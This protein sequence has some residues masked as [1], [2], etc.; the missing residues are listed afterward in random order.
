MSKSPPPMDDPN[1]EEMIEGDLAQLPPEETKEERTL[2]SVISS[3]PWFVIA[4]LLHVL[5]LTVL[6][7]IRLTE[8]KAENQAAP[9]QIT[10]NQPRVM[11]PVADTPP[12]EIIDRNQVPVLDNEQ[13]GPVNPD[14]NYI[15]EA[16]PGRQGEIIPDQLDPTKDPGIYNPDPEALSNL[17]SGATGGTAIGVGTQG[18][19][20]LGVSAFSSRRA[21]GDGKGGGGL[22][23]GGGGGRGGG[24]QTESVM[25]AALLWLANHQSPDGRWDCDGFDAH[26][27]KN[28]CDGRGEATYDVGVTGLALLC[29]LGAGFT[30]QEGPFKKTVKDGLLYLKSVQDEDGVFGGKLCPHYQ[31]NHACAAL[32]M[33]EAY[34]MTGANAFREPAVKGVAWVGVSQ[35]PYRAWRYGKADGDNDSSVTG[36]MTM[37]IKSAAMAGID[38]EQ[39]S[40]SN[41]ANFIDEMTEDNGRTGYQQKGGYPARVTGPAMEKFPAQNSES[42]TAVGILVRIFDGRT[43]GTDPKIMKGAE[44]LLA[45][46]PKWDPPFIDF[47]YWY[48]GTLAMYQ[49]GGSH[50]DRWNEAMKTAIIAHQNTD[51]TKDEFGSWDPVDP[52]SAEGGRVYSTALNCLCMEVYYR[53]PRVFGAKA[54]PKAAAPAKPPK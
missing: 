24:K 25:M 42:L 9:T 48:Y 19:L 20:G 41:A 52:W 5:A 16:T 17:P 47:Y 12:P 11:E 27:K 50:F 51:K 1:D 38:V 28:K 36:W 30:H 46:P 18:H 14:P 2:R 22:G 39:Q 34:G 53:Y 8:E 13:E 32:A 45:Q 37:V 15:P 31:Y 4:V 43:A 23:Q 49:V 7:V 6:T 44:L 29:F 40:L 33:A 26:C 10:L 21:G 54:D 35:N 3:A